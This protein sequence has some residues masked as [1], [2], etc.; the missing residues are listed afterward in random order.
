VILESSLTKLSFSSGLFPE[1]IFMASAEMACLQKVSAF[2][3][4][5][6]VL[7]RQSCTRFFC[8]D[9]IVKESAGPKFAMFFTVTPVFEL[10]S[11]AWNYV[12]KDYENIPD[13]ETR[14]FEDII[15]WQ[16]VPIYSITEWETEADMKAGE[17]SGYYQ[18]QIAKFGQILTSK[19]I[20]EGFEVSLQV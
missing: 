4:Y 13:E 15:T 16:D 9:D 7:F 1:L 3:S 11:I 6:P 14:Q 5:T 19:P 20:R 17:T 2:L 18:E 12:A 8:D 10:A